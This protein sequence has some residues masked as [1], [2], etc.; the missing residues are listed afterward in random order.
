MSPCHIEP[1]PR[2]EN[3]GLVWS[4]VKLEKMKKS[5]I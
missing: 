1:Y 5:E 3:V 4:R 2:G